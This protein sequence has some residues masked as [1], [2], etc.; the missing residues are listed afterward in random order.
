MGIFELFKIV[1][2]IIHLLGTNNFAK[3]CPSS[4]MQVTATK[5]RTLY[6]VL[7]RMQTV[8]RCAA[9][10]CIAL[11]IHK[12]A[13]NETGSESNT[14]CLISQSKIRYAALRS[15]SPAFFFM[16]CFDCLVVQ[17]TLFI[18]N[19]LYTSKIVV[20]IAIYHLIISSEAT[21]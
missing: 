7:A 9:L 11:K 10:Y 15:V 20:F 18:L 16:F 2:T 4:L 1:P 17:Y 3:H 13:L 6:A 5:V 8:L 19:V 21:L 14:V 12:N